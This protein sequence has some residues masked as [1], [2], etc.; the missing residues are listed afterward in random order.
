MSKHEPLLRS[1]LVG[2]DTRWVK[3]AGVIRVSFDFDIDAYLRGAGD[4]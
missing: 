4:R 3:T 1:S 2:M